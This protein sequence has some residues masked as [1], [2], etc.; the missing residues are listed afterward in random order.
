MESENMSQSGAD[1]DQTGSGQTS[2]EPSGSDQ[3]N[4][5]QAASDQTESEQSLSDD[6]FQE[7]T[8]LGSRFVT[9]VQSAWDS[10][11]RKQIQDDLKEGLSS[12]AESLEEGFQKVVDNEQA[13]DV[14]DK[15]DGVADSVGGKLR[16]SQAVS[17]LG[18][19][20]VKGLSILAGKLETWTEEMASRESGPDDSPPPTGSSTSDQS[21]DIPIDKG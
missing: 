16:S 15:A 18:E 8:V 14:I 6:L 5:G 2:G 21:Q 11:E 9:V 12:V 4:N 20:L 19:S 1:E 13:K 10:E 17:D 3:T 7:L